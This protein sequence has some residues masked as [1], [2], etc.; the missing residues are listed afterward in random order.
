MGQAIIQGR[1]IPIQGRLLPTG[2]IEGG[3]LLY[4]KP[5]KWEAEN[6]HV[7]VTTFPSG[8]RLISP[9]G[10]LDTQILRGYGGYYK[11]GIELEGIQQI[12]YT[13]T[14]A[15]AH[16]RVRLINSTS[17]KAQNT[18]PPLGGK[19]GPLTVL[20]NPCPTEEEYLSL[21]GAIAA[22]YAQLLVISEGEKVVLTSFLCEPVPGHPTFVNVYFQP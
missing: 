14:S 6:L 21:P 17:L 9:P 10:A 20:F 5:F 4:V 7:R 12:F 8:E 16:T 2:K 3:P 15:H 11:E 1:S 13:L 18:S 19:K 22:G